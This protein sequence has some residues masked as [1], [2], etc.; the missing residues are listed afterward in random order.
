MNLHIHLWRKAGHNI[1]RVQGTDRP[2]PTTVKAC[3]CGLYREIPWPRETMRM[4]RSR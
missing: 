3:R 2:W 4:P 1:I